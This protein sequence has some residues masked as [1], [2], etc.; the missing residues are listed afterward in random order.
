[1]EDKV[2]KNKHY[3]VVDLISMDHRFLRDSGR[4]LLD[5]Q[6]DPSDKLSEARIFLNLLKMHCSAKARTVYSDL[7]NEDEFKREI[8]DTQSR[9]R[10]V[11]DRLRSLHGRIT[12]IHWITPEL[13][14]ELKLLAESVSRILDLEERNLLPLMKKQLSELYLCDLGIR[15]ERFRKFTSQELERLPGLPLSVSRKVE[16]HLNPA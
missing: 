9:H 2:M 11:S 12:E 16:A 10:N 8:M 5:D 15:Y 7:K 1:M 4:I 14:T 6:A 13:A 3:S